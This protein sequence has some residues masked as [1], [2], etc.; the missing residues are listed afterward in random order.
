MENKEK[1]VQSMQVARFVSEIPDLSQAKPAPIG[2]DST[3]WTPTVDGESKRLFFMDLR[4]DQI[5]DDRTGE[6][7]DLETAYFVEPTPEGNVVIRQSS[8]WLV[9]VIERNADK[10]VEGTPFEITY[11]GKKRTKSGNQ[12]D[13]WSIVPLQI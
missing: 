2:L 4:T 12:C 9:G 13:T 5:M 10:I 1:K 6:L 8:K 3:Y 11:K 7:I